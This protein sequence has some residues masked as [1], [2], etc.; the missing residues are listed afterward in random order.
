[1]VDSAFVRTEVRYGERVK[2]QWPVQLVCSPLS[3]CAFH[4]YRIIDMYGTPR[5][6]SGKTNI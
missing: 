2:K 5:R 4:L 1:M 6:A 3:F